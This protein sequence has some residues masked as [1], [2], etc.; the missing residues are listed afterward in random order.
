MW[1]CRKKTLLTFI[2]ACM[3]LFFVIFYID[4]QFFFFLINHTK[5]Y[6]KRPIY[7][8]ETI[9]I[10]LKSISLRDWPVFIMTTSLRS[11]IKQ[12]RQFQLDIKAFPLLSIALVHFDDVKIWGCKIECLLQGPCFHLVLRRTFSDPIT[13]GQPRRITIYTWF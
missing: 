8:I 10:N 6:V 11:S 2:R 12:S 7:Y 4:L 1:N 13:N 3:G 9:L 5:C